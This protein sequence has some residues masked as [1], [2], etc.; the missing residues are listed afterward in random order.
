MLDQFVPLGEAQY[1]SGYFRFYFLCVF[2][3]P[4]ILEYFAGCI[5]SNFDYFIPVCSRCVFIRRLG[6][7]H[8]INN[9]ISMGFLYRKCKRQ[10]PEFN[11]DLSIIQY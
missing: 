10:Q 11:T 8:N 7:R 9:Y 5:D 3:E 6:I 2:M 1:F 4:S